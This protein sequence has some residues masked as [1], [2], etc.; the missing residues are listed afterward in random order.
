MS[1]LPKP[2]IASVSKSTWPG[3]YYYYNPVT[4]ESTF[5]H[6]LVHPDTGS[7]AKLYPKHSVS[8]SYVPP[9]VLPPQTVPKHTGVPDVPADLRG[10]A[11]APGTD[12]GRIALPIG[13][14]PSW[15]P[16]PP[17]VLGFVPKPPLV[18]SPSEQDAIRRV[19]RLGVN[20]AETSQPLHLQHADW[21]LWSDESRAKATEVWI[22]QCESLRL[23]ISEV[24]D[25]R[26]SLF[27]SDSFEASGVGPVY[28]VRVFPSENQGD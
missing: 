4:K 14:M 22:R 16:G 15:R 24:A 17:P 9:E 27:F 5:T 3:A 13:P 19:H 21:D 10:S 23:E 28:I 18:I 7:T 6:P 8:S 20:L 26:P 12:V 11:D 1:L 2:W 25:A